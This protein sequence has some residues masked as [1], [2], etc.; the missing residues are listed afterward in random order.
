[1]K[2]TRKSGTALGTIAVEGDSTRPAQTEG[3]PASLPPSEAVPDDQVAPAPSTKTAASRIK[4][5]APR[6]KAAGRIA[7]RKGGSARGEGPR[8]TLC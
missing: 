6:A 5:K 4:V 1:M 2:Q 8:R 3:S 7:G